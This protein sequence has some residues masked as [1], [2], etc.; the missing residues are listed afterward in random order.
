MYKRTYM[1]S[2]KDKYF[3]KKLAPKYLKCRVITKRSP[4]VYELEDMSGKNIG[5]WHIKDIKL[6][7]I[8]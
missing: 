2:D 3:C 5:V 7:N 6:V 8:R 1:L 4:L